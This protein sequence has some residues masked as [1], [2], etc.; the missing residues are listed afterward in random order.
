MFLLHGTPLSKQKIL[1]YNKRKKHNYS[2][3]MFVQINSIKLPKKRKLAHRKN[4]KTKRDM[5][6]RIDISQS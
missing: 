5:I 6:M 2:C 1:Q 3:Y 4:M